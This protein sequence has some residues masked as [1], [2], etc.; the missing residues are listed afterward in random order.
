MGDT[1]EILVNTQTGFGT[2]CGSYSEIFNEYVESKEQKRHKIQILGDCVIVDNCRR[3]STDNAER[4]CLKDALVAV[5][6]TDFMDTLQK[7]GWV[8]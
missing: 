8:S 1:G 4:P 6:L 3:A 7:K 2:A 5:W